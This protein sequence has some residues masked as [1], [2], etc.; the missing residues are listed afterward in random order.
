M[1]SEFGNEYRLFQKE[2][3]STTISRDD[4]R[5][6]MKDLSDL[7]MNP[8]FELESVGALIAA[9]DASDEKAIAVAAKGAVSGLIMISIN[10][11]REFRELVRDHGPFDPE[12]A[13][14]IIHEL[15]R[16]TGPANEAGR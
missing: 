16:V 9:L 2:Y 4:F 13:V 8:D 3:G 1:Q 6:I 11:L 5:A 7:D 12:E 15:N 14:Q 10:W